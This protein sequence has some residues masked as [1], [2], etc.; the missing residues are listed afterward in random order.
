MRS[1]GAQGCRRSHQVMRERVERTID[2]A[3]S[4]IAL[5]LFLPLL[6]CVAVAARSLYGGPVLVSDVSVGLRGRKFTRYRF[7]TMHA[8]STQATNAWCGAFLRQSGIEKL[9]VLFNVLRGDAN[10]IAPQP[11]G[12]V[13]NSGHSTGH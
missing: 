2:I 6:A 13:P 10:L 8:D 9:P 11:I 12:A 5:V 1:T 7:R 3:L 4:L